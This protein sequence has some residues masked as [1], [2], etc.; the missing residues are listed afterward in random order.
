[1]VEGEFDAIWR[2]VQADRESG[3]LS[4]EDQEKSE[5]QLKAE[6]RKIAERRVRLGLV[7]AEIGR[8]HDVTVSDAELNAAINAE[9]R[10]YPG[11]EREVFDAYRQRPDLQAGLR[12]PIYEEKV[13]DLILSKAQVEDRPVSR[14]ELFAEDEVPAAYSEGEAQPEAET[15]PKKKP[16]GKKAKADAE[17]TAEP[18]AEAVD[19][20]AAE[21]PAKKKAA[22]KKKADAE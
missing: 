15:K 14:D 3:E 9:A 11:Q 16:A 20:A 18:S 1:M 10:R 21:K 2:Q 5:E 7:L 13:V 8:A 6:Y 22:P 4:P 19:A 12:A 17:P